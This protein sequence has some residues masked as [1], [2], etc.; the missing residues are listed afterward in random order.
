MKTALFG[1]LAAGIVTVHASPI[2]LVANGSFEEGGTVVADN[3][4]WILYNPITGW[5][6]TG[7]VEV[8]SNGLYGAGSNAADGSHWLEMD[9]HLNGPGSVAI[10]Q[11]ITTV[12]GAQ[13]DLTFAFAG[14]PGE[15]STQNVLDVGI[16]GAMTRY[17]KG[18]TSPTLNWEYFT[19][20][21]IGTG[22]DVIYFADGGLATPG[23]NNTLGTL[24]DDVSVTAQ[25]VPEPGTLG[26]FG[27][28]MLGLAFAARRRAGRKA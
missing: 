8:Q 9:S 25:A 27:I 28:G 15:G 3:G 2:N 10:Q 18:S 7:A 6:S 26:L 22:S 19:L 14:R 24:L 21:F 13:Y 17:S 23:I 5:G 20:S 16:N 4:G 1:L 11:T 12:A